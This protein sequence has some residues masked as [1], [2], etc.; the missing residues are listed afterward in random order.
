M[1]IVSQMLIFDVD[2]VIT[3]PQ[4]KKITEPV[5]LDEIIKRL[6]RGEPVALNTGRS[7]EW[8]KDR[9]LK[10]LIEKIKDKKILQNLLTVGEKGGTWAEFNNQNNITENKDNNISAPTN[11][12]NEIR[13]LIKDNF[14]DSMFYDE[15]KLTM[16][17]TEMKDGHLLEDYRKKQKKLCAEFKMLLTKQSLTDK[18][19]IYSTTIAVDIENKFVGKH[20]AIKRIIGWINTKE[21]APQKFATIGD[22]FKSDIPMAEQLYSLGFP[23]EFVYVGNENIDT[24]NY[25]FKLSQTKAKFE[26]GTLEY[27]Q[28]L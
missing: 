12:K 27:L 1:Q 11:L 16:I 5:I 20:F 7:I 6:K 25:P 2:G 22:S 18:F 15:S 4:E 8:V 26:K 19:K 10:P 21:I 3:N 14:P 17:S 24:S 23:V 13:N 9:V 28:S